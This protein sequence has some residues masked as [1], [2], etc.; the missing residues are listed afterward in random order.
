MKTRTGPPK[1]LQSMVPIGAGRR[2]GRVVCPGRVDTHRT[3]SRTEAVIVDVVTALVVAVI[4]A[5]VALPIVWA[6]VS[7]YRWV[8]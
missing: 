5:A 2:P 8:L 6:L 4:V 1:H 3:T 7:A